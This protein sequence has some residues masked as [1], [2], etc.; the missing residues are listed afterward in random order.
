[1]I[2]TFIVVQED[3]LPLPSPSIV[4]RPIKPMVELSMRV[5]QAI[6]KVSP[7]PLI[8]L[9]LEIVLAKNCAMHRPSK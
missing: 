7:A 9:G 3:S 2:N 5:T 1:M 4:T 6:K 8:L